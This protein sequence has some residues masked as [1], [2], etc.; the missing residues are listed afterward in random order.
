MIRF[1]RAFAWIR[2]R[3]LVNSFTRVRR[4]DATAWLGRILSLLMPIL[5]FLMIAPTMLG[6]GALG[7]WGGWVLGGGSAW[8]SVAIEVAR[9][10][11]GIATL[12]VVIWPLI[13]S[14]QG[15]TLSVDR[16]L[17]LPVERGTL[18]LLEVAAGVADPVFLVL[19]PGMLLL[20][21]GLLAHGGAGP[22]LLAL[23]G[24]LLFLATL[25]PLASLTSFVLHLLLRNR[26][27][28]E[29]L[30]LAAILLVTLVGV[31]PALFSDDL[32]RRARREHD[33]A[34]QEAV[35][36]GE[37]APRFPIWLSPL[38]SELHA[39]ALY[40]SAP[41]G[42]GSAAWPLAGLAGEAAL[43]FAA[44]R[45]A[46]RRLVETPEA[47]GPRRRTAARPVRIARL[48]L[49][50]AAASAV[51]VVQVRTFMRTGRGKMAVFFTPLLT[52]VLALIVARKT[53]PA[54]PLG[55]GPG[56]LLTALGTLFAMMSL[57]AL[58][59]N[60]FATDGA[61]L[62]LQFL[63][64][65]SDRELISGK[66]AGAGILAACPAGLC[67]VMGMVLGGAGSFLLWPTLVLAGV[68]VFAVFAPMASLLSML[69]PR[70]SNLGS[71]GPTGNPHPA[72]GF[73]G[74][75]CTALAAAPVAALAAAALLLARSPALALALVAGW[76]LIAAAIG[77]GLVRIAAGILMERRESLALVASGR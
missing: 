77:Y 49:L 61:G 17:L 47:G 26:R 30:G 71:L 62:T 43:L 11:L 24:S 52:L 63:A 13:A 34:R 65:L 45:A 32:E 66:I 67:L 1:L 74:I 59:C 33:R 38:P 53:T 73:L 36:P 7:L 10:L 18:H 41:G 8:G 64:P 4:R 3:M 39:R 35:L 12:A 51:A 57:H 19:L 46:H 31:L 21:I 37:H 27:R 56:L 5:L 23:T 16:L 6:L 20:P 2:W 68:S 40:A 55:L 50:G 25:L 60:Q 54:A 29:Q 58:L 42:S 75:A 44:S 15:A 28:A 69:L 9:A 72:A 22:A 70:K 14:S 48:P 76:T